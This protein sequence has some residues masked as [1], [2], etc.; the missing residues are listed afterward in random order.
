MLIEPLP[1]D[2][3]LG[4]SCCLFLIRPFFSNFL[5]ARDAISP[6]SGFDCLGGS[7]PSGLRSE[8]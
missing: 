3:R 8:A 1:R 6:S 4:A 5:S 7:F 2:N